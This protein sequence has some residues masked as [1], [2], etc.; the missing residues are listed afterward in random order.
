MEVYNRAVVTQSCELSHNSHN[1]QPQNTLTK[2][3]TSM[4]QMDKFKIKHQAVCVCVCVCVTFW[5][6]AQGTE[7]S[8]SINVHNSP[9]MDPVPNRMK[10]VHTSVPVSLTFYLILSP[11]LWLGLPSIVLQSRF[12][13]IILH[14]FSSFPRRKHESTHFHMINLPILKS[15]NYEAPHYTTI[16]ILAL[17]IPPPI[18]NVLLSTLFAFT[19]SLSFPWRER[20]ILAAI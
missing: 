10:P 7:C 18:S 8:Q 20:H 1:S 16:F 3:Q 11:H 6:K 5:S 19:P 17:P 12:L 13:T 4:H 2:H 15:K 9:T 14:I